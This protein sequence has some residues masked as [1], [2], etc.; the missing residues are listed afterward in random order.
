MI[1]MLLSATLLTA[2]AVPSPLSV[3]EAVSLAKRHA[4]SLHAAQAQVEGADA[5]SRQALAAML[6]LGTASLN[7]SRATANFVARPG[8]LPSSLGSATSVSTLD[9]YDFW[10]GNVTASVTL[11]DFGQGFHSYQAARRSADG[12]RSTLG[13]TALELERQVRVAFFSAQAGEALVQVTES[14]LESAQTH[15][16]QAEAAVRIGTRPDI[17]VAQAK[18]LAASQKVALLKAKNDAMLLKAALLRTMGLEAA[19]VFTLAA[20]QVEP[21]EAES[22]PIE[23]LVESSVKARPDIAA[24]DAQIAAQELR[25]KSAWGA[26]FPTL[27]VQAQGTLQSRTL[28]SVTPNLSVAATLSWRGFEA[29]ATFAQH[30]A[31]QAQLR[32]LLAQRDDVKQGVRLAIEQSYF[33]VQMAS[34]AVGAAREA[35]VAA[36]EQLRLAEGRYQAGAGSI[37]ELSDAQAQAAVARGQV[38]QAELDLS[39]ARVN[40][41]A[42]L[43]RW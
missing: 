39:S 30:D 42:A 11:W 20:S 38:V 14:A 28:E 15:L 10:S 4:P 18:S 27:G 36:E 13:A 35:K 43:G 7:Y 33:T 16:R 5:S 21:V 29:S 37:I 12:Q 26:F 8:A 40:L 19:P 1:G 3:E 17:D 24:L 31:A 2:S 22:E 9:G 34:E 41:N 25:V 32:Q 23:A 6:P